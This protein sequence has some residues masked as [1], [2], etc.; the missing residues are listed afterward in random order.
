MW[1]LS[2]IGVSSFESGAKTTEQ[3]AAVEEAKQRCLL[4]SN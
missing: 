4:G 1:V 2:F 3:V